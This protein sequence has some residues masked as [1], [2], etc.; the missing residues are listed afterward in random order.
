MAERCW[1]EF[2]VGDPL[3]EIEFPLTVYR[4]IKVVASNRDFSQVHHN[5][6]Y[7]RMTGAPDLYANNIFL[8]GMWERAVREVIGPLGMIRRISAFRMRAFCTPGEVVVVKGHVSKKWK[9]GELAMV[10]WAIRTEGPKG[11]HVGPGTV[12]ASVRCGGPGGQPM[13]RG[14]K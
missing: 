5:S 7:A 14:G 1:D 11:V 10:E 8:Q 12:A 9:E 6:E 4:L 2:A 3:P 13:D